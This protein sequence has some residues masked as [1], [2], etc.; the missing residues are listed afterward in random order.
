M[1]AMKRLKLRGK[2]HLHFSKFLL[3]DI[4]KEELEP[5]TFCTDEVFRSQRK[6]DRDIRFRLKQMP[7]GQIVRE[8][9]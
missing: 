3:P 5:L 6:R 9:F 4:S 1:K 8:D 7:D 2:K